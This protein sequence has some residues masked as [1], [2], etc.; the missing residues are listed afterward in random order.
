MELTTNFPAQA[1]F[2]YLIVMVPIWLYV[3]WDDVAHLKIRNKVVILIAAI[4]VITGPFL[5]PLADYAWQVGQGIAVL[6]V[7]F[8]LYG[9]RLMGGGDAKFIAAASLYMHRSDVGLIF[10]IFGITFMVG[11]AV[12]RIMKGTIGPKLF[13]DWASWTSGKRFPMGLP[14][15]GWVCIY[16][17]LSL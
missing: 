17:Y 8:L 10:L 11:W 16:L 12:H 1:A 5:M 6:L 7:V 3:A 13:P 2:W 9:L 14:M 4:F 15:G